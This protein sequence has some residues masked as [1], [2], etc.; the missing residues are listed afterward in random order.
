M[1]VNFSF[2]QTYKGG[3]GDNRLQSTTN[4]IQSPKWQNPVRLTEKEGINVVCFCKKVNTVCNLKRRWAELVST[5]YWTF[6]FVK[7]SLPPGGK[8]MKQTLQLLFFY[9]LFSPGAMG[10]LDLSTNFEPFQSWPLQALARTVKKHSS[11]KICH[12]L[13]GCT[14][15]AMTLSIMTCR[16]IVNKMWHSG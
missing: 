9:R 15:G 3:S 2:F 13:D 5:L 7:S 4:H 11:I 16:I 12:L 8:I 6:P 14:K 10:R 1:W